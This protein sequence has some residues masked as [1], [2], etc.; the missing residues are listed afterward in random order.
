M[1][2]QY[3]ETRKQILTP[4]LVIHDM[5]DSGSFGKIAAPFMIVIPPIG[6]LFATLLTYLISGG[7]G[8]EFVVGPCCWWKR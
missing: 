6:A 1:A 8:A 5:Q 4:E 2:Y 3:S 7:K